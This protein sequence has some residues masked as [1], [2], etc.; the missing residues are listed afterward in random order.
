M[1]AINIYIYEDPGRLRQNRMTFL[2]D[3]MMMAHV[4]AHG[5]PVREWW[6]VIGPMIVSIRL[7]LMTVR[8]SRRSKSV[9]WRAVYMSRRVLPYAIAYLATS[10]DYPSF[11]PITLSLLVLEKTLFEVDYAVKSSLARNYWLLI[12]S[13]I[14]VQIGADW[15]FFV[16]VVLSAYR[17]TYVYATCGLLLN[18]SNWLNRPIMRMISFIPIPQLMVSP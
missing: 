9:F 3:A 15:P 13:L 17:R 11:S 18:A 12:R 5:Q 6:R 8:G 7:S 10:W 1:D 14:G 4:E 2:A 16:G